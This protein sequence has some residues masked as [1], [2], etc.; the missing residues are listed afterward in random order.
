[1]SGHERLPRD[2]YVRRRLMAGAIAALLL[3][4]GVGAAVELGRDDAPS[5]AS[6][7]PSTTSAPL[8][9]ASP[10]T[11]LAV[12]GQPPGSSTPATASTVAGGAPPSSATAV[13]GQAS[14]PDVDARAFA[15]YDASTDEWLAESGA[16]EALPV[17]S[18]MKLLTAK[19]VMDAGDPSKV[20]TVGDLQMD[21]MESAIGLYRGEQLGRDVLLRAMLIVSANDAARALAVDV[22]GSQDAF[23]AMMNQTAQSL[24][25]DTTV[26][27]N[28]VGLD[29][30]TAHSSARD[31]VRLADL[32]MEDET[33]RATVARTSAR[34]HGQT[35][36]TTNDLL[37]TYPGADGI[38][39]GH[40]TGAGYCLVASATRDGRRII[41]AV[42]GA[43]TDGARVAG[44]SALLDWAFAT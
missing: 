31:M 11:S 44:A 22:G 39:T 7:L 14:L 37:T 35:F 19:V 13:V 33:F 25:L 36:A 23:V 21:P 12:P 9:S 17:G 32:L 10:G 15:V 8:V 2:V 18:V 20:V 3:A 5:D 27:S 30:S 28:P 16:D 26:A 40:T 41:V 34:L 24:G 6:G 4:G 29:S 38:K 42:L 1:M 43:P